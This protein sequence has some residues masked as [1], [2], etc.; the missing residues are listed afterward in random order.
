MSSQQHCPI[1]SRSNVTDIQCFSITVSRHLSEV[2]LLPTLHPWTAFDQLQGA[3]LVSDLFLF[4]IYH[5]TRTG[6]PN[7]SERGKAPPPPQTTNPVHFVVCCINTIHRTMTA[8]GNPSI[9]TIFPGFLQ[10]TRWTR[11]EQQLFTTSPH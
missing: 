6:T 4:W 5:S 11:T 2:C 9:S 3:N 1:S 10:H 8:Q 7:S